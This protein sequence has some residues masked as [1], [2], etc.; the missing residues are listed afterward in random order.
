MLFH[1]VRIEEIIDD[2]KPANENGTSQR[3]KK[4]KNKL[5]GSDGNDNSPR[6]IVVKSGSG[7]PVMESEDEDGFPISS[8]DKRKSNFPNTEEKTEVKDKGIDEGAKKKK[9]K[10]D[11]V[12]SK[13]VKRKIHGDGDQLR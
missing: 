12:S 8:P 13:T 2:E 1:I 9:E 6:Q 10:D 7:V 5:S 3:P 4:K 11:T